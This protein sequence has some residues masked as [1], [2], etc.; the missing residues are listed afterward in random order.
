MKTAKRQLLSEFVMSPD[1][2]ARDGHL[3]TW[4]KTAKNA[5]DLYLSTIARDP[6]ATVVLT[7]T[8]EP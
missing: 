4:T 2:R 3:I 1:A 5:V 6:G 7:L 8:V